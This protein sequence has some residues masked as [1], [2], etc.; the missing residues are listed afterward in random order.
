MHWVFTCSSATLEKHFL[1]S[2]FI[3]T[4]CLRMKGFTFSTNFAIYFVNASFVKKFFRIL[5]FGSAT[6]PNI[7]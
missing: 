2:R 1:F 6:S 4:V 5:Q 3:K 7:F